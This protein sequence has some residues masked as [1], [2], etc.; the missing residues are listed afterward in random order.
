MWHVS[1]LTLLWKWGKI[2]FLSQYRNFVDGIWYL[3]TSLYFVWRSWPSKFIT[4]CRLEFDIRWDHIYHLFCLLMMFCLYVKQKI[5]TCVSGAK[6]EVASVSSIQVLYDLGW[7]FYFSL[8]V[9]PC[10][11]RVR[12][13]FIFKI[14]YKWKIIIAI[15][16][17]I[18]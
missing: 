17:I 14:L 12:L 6:Q 7:S 1:L 9:N 4:K 8:E 13:N 18:W 16:I 3:I 11:A 10:N 15:S 2:E 5:N